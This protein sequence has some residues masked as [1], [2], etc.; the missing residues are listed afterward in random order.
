[1]AERGMWLFAISARV[2]SVEFAGPLARGFVAPLNPALSRSRFNEDTSHETHCNRCGICVVVL[3]RSLGL[4][5]S[6]P[7]TAHNT[8]GGARTH[9][10][11]S[12]ARRHRISGKAT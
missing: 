9:E 1:M 6:R 5:S 7:G 11:R 4:C 12:V 3:V 8:T 10:A 2:T